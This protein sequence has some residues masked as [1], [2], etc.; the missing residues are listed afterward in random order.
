M[1]TVPLIVNS[2]YVNWVASTIMPNPKFLK[3]KGVLALFHL[4][5]LR[6]FYAGVPAV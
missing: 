1:A 3:N 5:F 2:L 4:V 6:S